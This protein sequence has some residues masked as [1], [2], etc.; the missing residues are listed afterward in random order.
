MTEVEVSTAQAELAALPQEWVSD[1]FRETILTR[2]SLQAVH[3]MVGERVAAATE[4]VN[5]ATTALVSQDPP[6]AA[7]SEVVATQQTLTAINDVRSIL[8][9]VTLDLS[10]CTQAFAAARQALAISAPVAPLPLDYADEMVRFQAF[11]RSN[12]GAHWVEAPIAT[13][14]DRAAQGPQEEADA[15]VKQWQSSV[16]L[17]RSVDPASSDPLGTLAS[18]QSYVD[19]AAT[20]ADAVEQA[21][22]VTNAA[23]IARTDAGLNWSAS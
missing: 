17:L 14:A 3:R 9:P 12:S 2:A 11:R 16:A 8:P 13:D 6:A 15:L 18:A 4:A 10:A 22:K 5:A 1:A 19:R 7:L 21:D 23:N 20:V